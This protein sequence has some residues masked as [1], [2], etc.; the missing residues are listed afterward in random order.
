MC[1]GGGRAPLPAH[2]ATASNHSEPF[3]SV[4]LPSAPTPPCLPR[5]LAWIGWT[6][7][8]S[9][10]P[11]F[12]LEGLPMQMGKVCQC[13]GPPLLLQDGTTPAFHQA[14]QYRNQAKFWLVLKPWLPGPYRETSGW[15]VGSAWLSRAGN[16]LSALNPRLSHLSLW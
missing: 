8:L 15:I 3:F 2:L 12:P 6:H 9:L 11:L 16:P 5:A 7:P 1:K 4:H 13:E 14:F 10:K